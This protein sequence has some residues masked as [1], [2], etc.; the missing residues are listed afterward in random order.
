MLSTQDIIEIAQKIEQNG[1]NSYRSAAS[2]VTNREL[3]A[4]LTWLAD[5]E[6]E[7]RRWFAELG[8]RLAPEQASPELEAMGRSML[9]NVVGDKAFSLDD[10]DLTQLPSVTKVLEAAIEVEA[11]T[12]IFYQMIGAFVSD[13]PTLEQLEA[14]IEEEKRHGR[15]LTEFLDTGELPADVG[16]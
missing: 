5:Q 7:H 11:D 3:A 15:L 4:L 12:V 10:I 1:E 16:G 2:K 14:I 9:L 8:R 13:A 6:A